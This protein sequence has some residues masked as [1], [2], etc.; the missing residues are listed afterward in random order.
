MRSM[1]QM[2]LSSAGSNMESQAQQR[3]HIVEFTKEAVK[4]RTALDKQKLQNDK[5][6]PARAAE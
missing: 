6:A 3:D 4:H 1:T 5:P 2:F